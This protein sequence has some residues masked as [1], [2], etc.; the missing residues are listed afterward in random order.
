MFNIVKKNNNNNKIPGGASGVKNPKNKYTREQI[1]GLLSGYIPVDE[2]K[3]SDIPVESHI[4]Y[5]KKDGVFVRGGFV[6]NHWLDKKG[7]KFIHLSNN[8]NKNADG[9]ATWP[10]AHNSV[11]RVF[12]KINKKNGIEMDVVR[13]KTAEIIEQINKLVDVVKNQGARLDRLEQRL[14][15]S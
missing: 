6:T 15:N 14:I 12:K 8:L 11:Q 7:N 9:Y 5:L 2:N 1:K 3:W 4:R 10:M 13:G